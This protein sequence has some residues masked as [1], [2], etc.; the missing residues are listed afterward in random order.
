MTVVQ[1]IQRVI[2][3]VLDSVGIG[4]LPDADQFGDEGSDTLRNTARAVGGLH[5]ANLE[6]LGLGNIHP[7]A[8]VPAVDEPLAAYG[9]MAEQSVAKD[10]T[11]G[12]WEI[13][14]LISTVAFP[15]YPQ[16]FPADLIA[17]YERRIGRKTLGNY[18]A[19]G[20]VI[21]EEL[22]VEHMR[23]GWPIVY[24]SG[25]SVFQVAAHEDVIPVEELYA[26]CQTAREMLTGEHNVGRVIAR[27]FVGT[28]GAFHRT[29]RRRDFSAPPPGP[30]LL[31]HVLAAGQ[32]MWAVGKIEDIFAG[33]GIG[34]AVHTHDNMDGVDKTLEAMQEAGPGLIFTNLVDF[35]MRFGHRNNPQGYAAALQAADERVPELMEALRRDDVLIFTADHGCDP[36]TASTDHSREYVPLLVYGSAIQGGVDL[37]TRPT[38]ADLGATVAEWL[39]VTPPDAGESFAHQLHKESMVE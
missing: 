34:H 38:F 29:D 39:R 22:G 6:R 5:L 2:L 25:D 10:T 33:Q 18:P 21:I 1:E 17:E 37:G 11:I 15:T 19:S 16:G 23:T 4:A 26:I 7:V 8:G 14:G 32:T 35:D 3:I 12:H 30:T 27:P 24:T 13:A 36:T 9:R 31:D 20:T 28:A